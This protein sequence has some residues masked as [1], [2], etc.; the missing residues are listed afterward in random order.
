MIPSLVKKSIRDITRKKAR[1]FFLIASIA[2]GVVGLS[3]TAVVPLGDQAVYD[4]IEEENM[5]NLKIRFEAVPLNDTVLQGLGEIENVVDVEPRIEYKC[6]MYIG[7]RRNWALFVGADGLS[8]ETVDRIILSSGDIPTLGEVLA[9]EADA[10]NGV[11]YGKKGDEFR[12][13]RHD[14]SSCSVHISGKGKNLIASGETREGVA[15]FYANAETVRNLSGLDGFNSLVFT[16]ERTD[17]TSMDATIEAIRTHLESKLPVVAFS[18]LPEVRPEGYYEGKEKLQQF[19]DFF[20]IFSVLILV[21]SIFLIA[22]TMNTMI[23]EQTREIAQMKCVGATRFDIFRSYLRTSMIIGLIGSFIGSMLGI[24]MAYMV[25]VQYIKV[26]GFHP[27]LDVHIWTVVL[28]IIVGTVVSMIA[29]VPA[30]MKAVRIDILKALSNK[31]IESGTGA[32]LIEIPLMGIK[33]I[34]RLARMGIRNVNRKM[35][36]S[37]ATILQISMSVAVIIALPLLGSSLYDAVH[38]NWDD[39]NWDMQV[40]F[41]R[42]PEDPVNLTYGTELINTV[43]GVD[44]IEPFV[45]IDGTLKGRSGHIYGMVQDTWSL[46]YSDTLLKNGE[47]RWWTAEEETKGSSV[48]ILGY[49]MAQFT[50]TDLGEEIELMTATGAYKFTVIGIDDTNWDDGIIFRMPITTLQN[51]LEVGDAIGGL[52]IRT[53]S[54]DHAEIDKTAESIWKVLE[55]KGMNPSLGVH[56]VLEEE[57]RV[58]VQ[59]VPDLMF[60]I[61]SVIVFTTLLGLASTLTMNILD[62][63][64]EI[65]ML[66]CVGAGS[67]SISAVF[68]TEGLLLAKIGWFLG[69]PMGL[70]LY[71]LLLVMVKD[72]MKLTLLWHFSWSF[73]LISL[74]VTFVGTLVVILMPVMRA[75]R[76]RPGEA[77]RYE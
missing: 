45:M 36:R 61:G 15:A 25:L 24:L 64:K 33:A 3:L 17:K 30:L 23:S 77:L 5:H 11:F 16:M 2:L 21:C 34:P 51:V 41:N 27:D 32:K 42:G 59:I 43:P 26:F 49:A 54:K 56:Y 74:A 19:G 50:G 67:I 38:G 39:Q 52:Y 69:V 46:D 55:G 63:T 73:I 4:M 58:S 68:A 40:F 7:E 8:D 62:R 60:T 6:K 31:G 44:G 37:L 72:V 14:M 71:W 28:S 12:V 10:M 18:D 76:F 66:R 1:S 70:G 53:A 65:G 35:G 20:M 47:G 22:N 9:D 57:N 48:I 13:I 75:V 29:C